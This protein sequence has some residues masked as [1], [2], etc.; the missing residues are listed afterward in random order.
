MIR[1]QAQPGTPAAYNGCLPISDIA[2]RV[3][4]QSEA[5][6]N[7]A[8]KQLEGTTPGAYR[9]SQNRSFAYVVAPHDS[10]Q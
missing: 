7:K 8:F 6:F 2:E 1:A 4:Y 3:G 5:S 9:R 10:T